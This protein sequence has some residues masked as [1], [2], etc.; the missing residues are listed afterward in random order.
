MKKNIQP[1]RTSTP[2][3]MA[4][5]LPAGALLRRHVQDTILTT[6]LK[7]GYRE[8][9]PPVFEYLD[10]LARGL[11]SVLLEKSYKF[12]DR[13]SGK[14]MILR[15]D[16]TP[17]V[18]R[19]VAGILAE[20]PKPLRLCYYGN[21]F[22]YEESHAG[23]EREMFQ[24]GCE[25]AGVASP[26]AD[27]E[28][29]AVAS[30]SIKRFGIDDFKIVISHAGYLSG[31]VSYIKHSMKTPFSPDSEHALRDAISKKDGC[32]IESVLDYAGADALAKESIM[33]ALRLYG[34][35][36]VLD[37][38]AVVINN[39]ESTDAIKNLNEIY[40]L[41]CLY[42][43]KG[44][45]LIDLCEMR[46]IDYYTGLFF[47]IFHSGVAFPIGRG[48]RYDNLIGK[49]GYECPSTGFAIDVESIIMAKER[50]GVPLPDDGIKYLVFSHDKY[51][52]DAM[53]LSGVL[54]NAGHKVALNTGLETTDMAVEYAINNNIEK[55]IIIE[56]KY[57]KQL[58]V[59]DVRTG[60]RTHI[61]IDK[62]IGG[63]R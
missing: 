61:D 45:I 53:D 49:F 5:H 23:L 7:W 1:S 51:R 2:R 31:I 6:F 54:R 62:L 55:I 15:P 3:G 34:T 10:V 12:V 21:I 56:E 29:I 25:L 28:I 48:G 50:Y 33:L 20:E 24:V 9:I 30:E 18:A 13:D 8:V 35:D 11:S 39:A 37:K 36:D 43:L 57:D 22:R 40:E 63:M 52:H 32:R 19:M 38:A 16:I 27:A 44:H 59:I 4:T 60:R 58:S 42:G 47:E 41:L 26:E 46:G 14:L 17:Q